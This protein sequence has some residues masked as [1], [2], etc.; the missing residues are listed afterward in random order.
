MD[1]I[2]INIDLENEE[3]DTTNEA[4][5]ENIQI[6]NRFI[7]QLITSL[8]IIGFCIYSIVAEGKL[9]NKDSLIY[10]MLGGTSALWLPSPKVL[11]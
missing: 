10:A 7:I 2:I 6:R 8:T 3:P 1:D 11:K 9:P 4:E 5:T